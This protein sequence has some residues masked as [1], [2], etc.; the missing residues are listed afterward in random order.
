MKSEDL[1]MPREQQAMLDLAA[2]AVATEV[3]PDEYYSKYFGCNFRLNMGRTPTPE[4]CAS[5]DEVCFNRLILLTLIEN[6]KKPVFELCQSV[7]HKPPKFKKE[8]WYK[9]KCNFGDSAEHLHYK[10]VK[11]FDKIMF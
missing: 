11:S 4:E 7:R 9:F 1:D 2:D 3:D 5:D 8:T 10:V 6:I